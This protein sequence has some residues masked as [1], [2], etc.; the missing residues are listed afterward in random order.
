MENDLS[1]EEIIEDEQEDEDNDVVNELPLILLVAQEKDELEIGDGEGDRGFLVGG[2]GV[3]GA[4]EITSLSWTLL[5]LVSSW[6]FLLGQHL[7]M[8]EPIDLGILNSETEMRG[9]FFWLYGAHYW[10]VGIRIKVLE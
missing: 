9:G 3:M 1:F 8:Q 2:I 5:L 6:G 4:C 7:L 10:R